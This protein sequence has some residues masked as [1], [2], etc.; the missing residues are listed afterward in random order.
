[1]E[2]QG[3]GMLFGTMLM[4]ESLKPVIVYQTLNSQLNFR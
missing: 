3:N 2:L 1:M 4:N